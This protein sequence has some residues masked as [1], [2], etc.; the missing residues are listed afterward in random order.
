M[1]NPQFCGV[2]VRV[3]V[4]V[5][6]VVDVELVV[7]VAEPVVVVPAGAVVVASIP[8]V[9]VDE[10]PEPVP[11]IGAEVPRSPG[12]D[13]VVVVVPAGVVRSPVVVVVVDGIELDVEVS[14]VGVVPGH[15]DVDA[16][17]PCPPS[18][19]A[20]YPWSAMAGAWLAPASQVAV[21]SEPVVAAQSTAPVVA[22]PR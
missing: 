18:N 21:P 19:A 11:V 10:T 20:E 1:G 13:V 22:V 14:V 17:R 2:V 8:V 9:V 15:V 16:A 4:A 12:E 5:P 6:A 3:V 7:V